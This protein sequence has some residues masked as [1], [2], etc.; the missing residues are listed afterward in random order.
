MPGYGMIVSLWCGPEA[1]STYPDAQRE[2]AARMA[3]VVKALGDPIRLQ[4]VD[5]LRH[6]AGKV[7]VCELVP[8]FHISQPTLSH[9]LAHAAW[10]RHR[11]LRAPRFAGLLLRPHR[12]AEGAVGL[13]GLTE[14][15]Q[16][17]SLADGARTVKPM[18]YR[19]LGGR[20]ARFAATVLVL[21]A[22]G[23]PAVAVAARGS[24]ARAGAVAPD[25]SDGPAG[26]Q[27]LD[28]LPPDFVAAI[29]RPGDHDWYALRGRA[30]GEEPDLTRVNVVVVQPGSGCVAP[31]P[32]LVGL[33]NPEG[34]WVRTYAGGPS[35]SSFGLPPLPGRYYLNVRAADAGCVGLQYT[36]SIA[37]AV[38]G[39]AIVA[40]AVALCRIAHNERVSAARELRS[41]ERR[42]RSVRSRAARRRHAR[43]VKTQRAELRR[44]RARERRTCAHVG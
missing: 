39:Q 9:H 20:S 35:G 18:G 28:R 40:G 17:L 44:A 43:Y 10:R 5:V 38:K 2:Q 42:R 41:L 24:D 13:A 34:R 23:T 3:T 37:H 15:A 12:C 11:R 1:C 7:C 19:R 6:H 21:V 16:R 36:F 32:L 4:L 8:L 22:A 27:T 30:I 31:Q 29:D 26:A 33:H 25:A 14:N